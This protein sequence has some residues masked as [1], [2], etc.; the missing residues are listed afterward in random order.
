MSG[1]LT[2]QYRP[3]LRRKARDRARLGYRY[4]VTDEGVFVTNLAGELLVTQ[5]NFNRRNR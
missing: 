2:H 5:K 4:I 3:N 1:I